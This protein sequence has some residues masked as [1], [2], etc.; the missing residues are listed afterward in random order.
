MLRL[1]GVAFAGAAEEIADGCWYEGEEEEEE[2]EEEEAAL[3]SAA[4]CACFRLFMGL[5]VDDIGA[6]TV[7]DWKGRPFAGD[8][9]DLVLSSSLSLSS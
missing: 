8:E 4:A 7:E 2:E 1:A 6:A 9:D 3:A 5:A